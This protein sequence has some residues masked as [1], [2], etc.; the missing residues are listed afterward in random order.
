MNKY[1]NRSADDETIKVI[2]SIEKRREIENDERM[3]QFNVK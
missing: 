1:A 2:Q 3:T